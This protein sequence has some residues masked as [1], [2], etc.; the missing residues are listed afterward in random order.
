MRYLLG[1]NRLQCADVVQ[2]LLN[3]C[4]AM[5]NVH[6]KANMTPLMYACQANDISLI[7]LLLKHG[8][9]VQYDTNRSTPLHVV[10]T[11]ECARLLLPTG[12][13]WCCGPHN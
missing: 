7:E 9:S 4:T 1:I 12:M 6:D 13:F 10:H 8:A 2:L 3:K 11:I 5:L